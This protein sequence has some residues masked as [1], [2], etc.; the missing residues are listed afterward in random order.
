MIAA[1]AVSDRVY[2]ASRL[3]PARKSLEGRPSLLADCHTAALYES[4][5][6]HR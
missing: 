6:D 4:A 3:A 2:K 5:K 1:D